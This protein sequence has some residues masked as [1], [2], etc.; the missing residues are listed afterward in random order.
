MKRT[1]SIGS[2]V[3]PAETTTRRPASDGGVSARRTASTITSGSARRPL[4]MSPPARRPSAGGTIRT[5]RSRSVVRFCCTAG[6]SHISVCM[7]GHTITGARVA[8]SV[9]VSR[10][11][12]MPAA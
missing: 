6:C 11:F 12:E 5:P 10:S 9:A 3:P 4:P 2:R 7:A 8:S 1:G